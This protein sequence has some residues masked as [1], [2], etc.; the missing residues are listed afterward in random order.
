LGSQ[1]KKTTTN[2]HDEQRTKNIFKISILI[3]ATGDRSRRSEILPTVSP[4][5][6][7]VYGDNFHRDSKNKILSE[8][9][10]SGGRRF[11]KE[12]ELGLFTR[13]EVGDPAKKRSD[14]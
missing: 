10:A 13:K 5:F 12:E 8:F 6:P 3:I 7:D 9:E 11:Y 4:C 2:R 14:F 1:G